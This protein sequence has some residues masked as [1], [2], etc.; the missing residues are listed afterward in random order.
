MVRLVNDLDAGAID[1]RLLAG[2]TAVCEGTADLS[3]KGGATARVPAAAVA[4]H[5]GEVL[6]LEASLPTPGGAS[7]HSEARIRVE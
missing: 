3:A 6:T 2:D 7:L 5:A 1:L 4:G